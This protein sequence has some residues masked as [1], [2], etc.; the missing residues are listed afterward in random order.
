M[1]PQLPATCQHHHGCLAIF[2]RSI[3]QREILTLKNFS[4]NPA[5][6]KVSKFHHA[7]FQTHTHTHTHKKKAKM[8]NLFLLQLTDSPLPINF[9]S[10][11]S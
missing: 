9:L 3:A 8:L 10:S 6:S 2:L 11:L 7:D 1:D 5:P 4:P